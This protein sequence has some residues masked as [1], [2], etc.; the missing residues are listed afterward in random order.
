MTNGFSVPNGTYTVKLHFAEIYSGTFEN[1]A[2]VFSVDMEGSRVLTNLD[3][4]SDV[5]A[6]AALVK[7]FQVTVTDGTLN[8]ATVPNVENPKLAA[9]E[10][11]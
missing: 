10:I 9:I 5:G 6:N 11:Y 7:T 3:I 1:G 8:L 4:H 2:R